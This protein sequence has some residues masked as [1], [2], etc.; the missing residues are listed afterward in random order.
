MKTCGLLVF[1]LVL[2]EICL[3]FLQISV[4]R[5]AFFFECYGTFAVS[6]Y[7]Q[8][9]IGRIFVKICSFWASFFGFATLILYLIFLLIFRFADFS[10]QRILG[11][12]FG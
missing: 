11:L 10:W 5:I 4:L 1:G 8:R 7:C 6:I 9:H 2:I 12:F 3:F